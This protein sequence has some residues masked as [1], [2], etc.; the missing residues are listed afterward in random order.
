MELIYNRVNPTFAQPRGELS[1]PGP[2]WLAIPR[3]ADEATWGLHGKIHSQGLINLD[4]LSSAY[5]EK[6]ESYD[7]SD[8]IDDQQYSKIIAD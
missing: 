6:S 8:G 3:I 4:G 5:A 1:H 2:M 7:T